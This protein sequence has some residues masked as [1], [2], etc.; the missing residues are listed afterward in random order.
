LKVKKADDQQWS[1]VELGDVVICP[2][3]FGGRFGGVQE[4]G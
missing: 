1:C 4:G 3:S 2:P